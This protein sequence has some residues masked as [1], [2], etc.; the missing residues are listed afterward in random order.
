MKNYM[1]PV[2]ELIPGEYC[3][4]IVRRVFSLLFICDFL[5][6]RKHDREPSRQSER[7]D[8]LCKRHRSPA[9]GII[10]NIWLWFDRCGVRRRNIWDYKALRSGYGE[11][12]FRRSGAPPVRAGRFGSPRRLTDHVERP[13]LRAAR[14]CLSAREILPI[15]SAHGHTLRSVFLPNARQPTTKE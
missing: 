11:P 4:T 10:I 12:G 3:C 2:H 13:Q 1:P 5:V 7:R 9:R 15:S 8:F 14:R 6:C